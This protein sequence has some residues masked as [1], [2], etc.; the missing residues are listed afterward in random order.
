MSPRRYDMTRKRA[1]AAETRK[2][3]VEATLKLH[4]EK[5]V[6]GTSWADIAREADVAIGTVYRNFP[7][8]D[9]LVPACGEL[10]MERT[11]PPAPD[12]IGWILGDAA[13]PVVRLRRVA[14]TVFG[15]Y[16]RG[17][18]YLEADIRE[19]ELPAM[20][21]WEEYLRSMVQG[22]VLEALKDVPVAD[23]LK[24]QTC[25]LFD[26]PTFSAMRLRS[27]GERDAIAT[28]TGLVS[29]WLGLGTT[30]STM[31]KGNARDRRGKKQ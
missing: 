14:E 15:F 6:F 20:R 4:G 7:T 13:D 11:Q 24:R 18:K 12:D 25:F 26:V 3:I 8:L 17:G 22:F 21:E 5:G 9:E 19:R 2:R 30:E 16:G 28:V 10:L 27:L 31:S 23:D 29:C 1:G